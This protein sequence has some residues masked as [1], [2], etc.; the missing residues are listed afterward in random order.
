VQVWLHI[1]RFRG[2]LHEIRGRGLGCLFDHLLHNG[3]EKNV[4]SRKML[5]CLMGEMR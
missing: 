3:R 4:V 5:K 1:G 2:V